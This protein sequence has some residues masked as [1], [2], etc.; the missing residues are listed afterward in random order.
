MVCW[1][2]NTLKKVVRWDR[3]KTEE[4]NPVFWLEESLGNSVQHLTML[5]PKAQYLW[6]VKKISYVYLSKRSCSSVHSLDVWQNLH[7]IQIDCNQMAFNLIFS[8]FWTILC[9]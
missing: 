1:I 6:G 4:E 2:K 3:S 9:W 7:Y 5:R 8:P